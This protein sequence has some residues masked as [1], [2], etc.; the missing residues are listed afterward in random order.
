MTMTTSMMAKMEQFFSPRLTLYWKGYH[1]RL[2]DGYWPDRIEDRDLLLQFLR[3]ARLPVRIS[4]T[5]S[6]ENLDRVIEVAGSHGYSVAIE[7]EPEITEEPA[8][9]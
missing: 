7:N 4:V 3:E 6:R 1:G 9:A 5:V 2:P 8:G